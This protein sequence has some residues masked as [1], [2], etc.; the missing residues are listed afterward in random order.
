MFIISKILQMLSNN[1]D[2]LGST[3]NV[4]RWIMDHGSEVWITYTSDHIFRYAQ[5]FVLVT[6]QL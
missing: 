1:V 4:D 5:V 2:A 3:E 6:K